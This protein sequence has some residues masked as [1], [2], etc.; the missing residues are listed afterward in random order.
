MDHE[1]VS[2][3]EEVVQTDYDEEIQNDYIDT[4]TTLNII[5]ESVRE[6]IV[7]EEGPVQNIKRIS[8]EKIPNKTTENVEYVV[9]E[10]NSYEDEDKENYGAPLRRSMSVGCLNLA[11]IIPNVHELENAYSMEENLWYVIEKLYCDEFNN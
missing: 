1:L 9:I 6:Y 11:G 10:D 3:K 8:Y 4:T 2:C 5:E 7:T